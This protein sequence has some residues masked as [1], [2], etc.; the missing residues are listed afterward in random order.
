[1]D[2]KLNIFQLRSGRRQGWS[3]LFNT[4]LEVVA[5]LVRQKK[6]VKGIGKEE[7]RTVFIHR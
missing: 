3:L 1:M 5:N 7:I 2:E 4:V 6:E